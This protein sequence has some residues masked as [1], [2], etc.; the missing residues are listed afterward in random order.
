MVDFESTPNFVW[1]ISPTGLTPYTSLFFTMYAPYRQCGVGRGLVTWV[2][3]LDETTTTP[4]VVYSLQVCLVF[5]APVF[6]HTRRGGE[7][8]KG[9]GC[10][11]HMGSTHLLVPKSLRCGREFWHRTN[12]FAHRSRNCVT[13]THVSQESQK[14]LVLPQKN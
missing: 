4:L 1:D 2:C 14:T 11:S 10:M 3:G 7:G 12:S 13:N 6:T 5:N 9:F 8:D